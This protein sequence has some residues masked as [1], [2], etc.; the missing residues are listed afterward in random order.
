MEDIFRKGLFTPMT[1]E[2]AVDAILAV[3]EVLPKQMVIH[4]LTSDPHPDELVAPVWMLDRTR[5]RAYLNS[6]MERRN[7]F[8]GCKTWSG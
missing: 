8:Q 7:V 1:M 6:E 2:E 3:L 4:R 5:V